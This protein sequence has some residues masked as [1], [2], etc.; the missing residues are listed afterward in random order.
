[1]H[2]LLVGFSLLI[3]QVRGSTLQF[4]GGLLP[5]QGPRIH[6]Q[7][8]ALVPAWARSHSSGGYKMQEQVRVQDR[9][10]RC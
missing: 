4:P 7:H 9:E 10:P 3:P 5:L 2:V 6:T 1:M 8:L